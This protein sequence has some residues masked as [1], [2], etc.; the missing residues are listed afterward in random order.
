MRE[1]P[2]PCTRVCRIDQ[3]TGWC[4]GCRR[5]LGEI[6]DWPMLD[7][8]EKRALLARLETRG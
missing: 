4:L 8:E 7:A 5:T 1:P 6:A 3:R 2:S